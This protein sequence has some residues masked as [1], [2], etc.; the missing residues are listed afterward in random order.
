MMHRVSK[1][2]VKEF[3]MLVSQRR[4]IADPTG[5]ETSRGGVDERLKQREKKGERERI[6]DNERS[7]EVEKKERRE[8][9]NKREM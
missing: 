5:C 2:Y 6:G 4:R 1:A 9:E 8:G 7:R 3:A